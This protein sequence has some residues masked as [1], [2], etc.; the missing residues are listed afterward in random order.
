MKINNRP[1][2][3]NVKKEEEYSCD[4]DLLVI[5]IAQCR[6]S[7]TA[8]HAEP[9]HFEFLLQPENSRETEGLT[10]LIAFS[11][12]FN[13][14]HTAPVKRLGKPIHRKFVL[15]SR[16]LALQ[17][18]RY[19]LKASQ[20]VKFFS[21][22]FARSYAKREGL[23]VQRKWLAVVLVLLLLVN[24]KRIWFVSSRMV[25]LVVHSVRMMWELADH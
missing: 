22:P 14:Q 16:N 9:Y 24:A 18:P 17:A 12:G 10:H 3:V 5:E 6:N 15:S 23:C 21:Q 20:L 8:L 1:I 11:G 4:G 25:A 2:I 19:D 7:E 13:E